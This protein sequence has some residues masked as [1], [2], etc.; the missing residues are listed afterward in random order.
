MILRKV[1]VVLFITLDGVLQA[2]GGSK[3]D[4]AEGFK[5]GGWMGPY[6]DDFL[7]K[8]MD[9]QMS[10]RSDL[11]LGHKTYEIFAGYWPQHADGWPGI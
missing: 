5:Y 3:E 1:I 11:L 2:P 6:M 9:E 10:G 8:V 7:G 4:T